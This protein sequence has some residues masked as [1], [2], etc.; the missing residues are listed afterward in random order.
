M[1]NAP[2][3]LDELDIEPMYDRIIVERDEAKEVTGGGL[4]IPTVAK[5]N[6]L[7]GTV[8]SVGEGRVSETGDV[9]PLSIKKGARILFGL[10]AGTEIEHNGNTYLLMAEHEILA[11]LK[12]AD[13]G[14]GRAS[15]RK[16][17]LE[18]EGRDSEEE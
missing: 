17:L 2:D 14:G 3:R 6:S 10:N 12:G 15:R 5:Q 8:V 11:V 1:S 7:V 13:G 16:L 9:V 4:L 18:G